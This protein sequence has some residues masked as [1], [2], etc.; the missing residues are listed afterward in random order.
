[1]KKHELLEKDV[2][3]EELASLTKNF[4]GA[5]IAGLIK[6]ASSFAFNRHIK[7]FL[8]NNLTKK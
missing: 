3:L 7:V 8:S 1:M 4:S 5:E 6:S 2:S